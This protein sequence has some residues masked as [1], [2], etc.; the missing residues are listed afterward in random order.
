MATC[1]SAQEREQILKF[2]KQ[3]NGYRYYDELMELQRKASLLYTIIP[4]NS[5]KLMLL[6][7]SLI[8]KLSI[9]PRRKKILKNVPEQY[10]EKLDANL[11]PKK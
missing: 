3:E 2:F 1:I 8:D 11:T 6:V 9:Y 7:R 4:D 10:R 5:S